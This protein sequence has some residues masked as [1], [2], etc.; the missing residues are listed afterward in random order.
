MFNTL[1][2]LGNLISSIGNDLICIKK[3]I[4][5]N[6]ITQNFCLRK[7][8]EEGHDLAL[9]D[10]FVYTLKK[11]KKI[12]LDYIKIRE[13]LINDW[14]PENKELKKF[15]ELLDHGVNGSLYMYLTAKRWGNGKT[16][17]IYEHILK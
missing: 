6:E 4:E 15:I 14:F 16:F 3:E 8:T 12:T 17:E 1:Y 13:L 11:L 2:D 7:A 9:T 5:Q 10:A